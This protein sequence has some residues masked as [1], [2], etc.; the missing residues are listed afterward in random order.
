MGI[1]KL[2]NEEKLPQYFVCVICGKQVS[3][4]L[5]TAGIADNAHTLRFACNGHFWN[6]HQFIVGWANFLATE[7]ANRTQRQFLLEY[8]EATHARALC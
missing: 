2:G 5:A 6:A 3:P 4:D 7:R 1:T 8:G